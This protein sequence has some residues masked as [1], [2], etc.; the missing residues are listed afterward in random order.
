MCVR[1]GGR[2]GEV[3]IEASISEER[4][5]KKDAA[6]CHRLLTRE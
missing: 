3:W 5:A 1:G 4:W 2:E 6:I